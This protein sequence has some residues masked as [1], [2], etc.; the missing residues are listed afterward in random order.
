MKCY[1]KKESKE[2]IQV[3]DFGISP[4]R[5]VV[6]DCKFCRVESKH[7]LGSVRST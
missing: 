3:L 2:R 4:E 6:D 5:E 7:R 1:K